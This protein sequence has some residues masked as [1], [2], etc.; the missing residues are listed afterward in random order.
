[1]NSES[2]AQVRVARWDADEETLQRI[3]S[4][5]FVLEQGVPRSIEWD[6]KDSEAGHVIA[7]LDGE[8]VG[9]GRLLPEGRIGRLAVLEAYRGRGLGRLMLDALISEA[10]KTGM[11]GVHLHAQANAIDFYE[12]AGFVAEGERFL[13]ADIEHQNMLLE[14]DY[15]EWNAPVTAPYPIPFDQLAVAQ[16]RLCGRELRVLS[17]QL[18]PRVFDQEDFLDALRAFVRHSR[19]S[20]VRILVQ[21]ARAIVQRGHGLLSLARRLP[22]SIELRRLAEHP[23]WNGETQVLRDRDSVL[24]LPGTESSKAFYRPGDRAGCEQA[25]NRFEELWRAG[26]VDPE[27]R[28]LSL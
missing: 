6:G 14:L 9:C 3:R 11:A 16:A 25:I 8:P 17:P 27:F 23:E 1:M 21:D 15:R 26:V 28:S 24:N 4:A 13:E 12:K 18:D 2:T 19:Q 22:S 10:R 5:V 7:E 20:Q